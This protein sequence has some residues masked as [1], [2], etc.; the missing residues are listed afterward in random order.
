MFRLAFGT[1][2]LVATTLVSAAEPVVR[3]PVP[4]KAAADKA[5]KQVIGLFK[6]DFAKKRP[7]DQVALA[8]RLLAVADGTRDDPTA[9]Y[10]LYREAW[11]A[12]ARGGDLVVFKKAV[13]AAASVYELDALAV[14]SAGL[15]T[16]EAAGAAPPG[17]AAEAAFL[18]AE[19]AIRSDQYTVASAALKTAV[20]A[21]KRAKLTLL[22]SAALARSEQ[23]DAIRQ[24]HAAIAADRTKLAAEADHVP[25]ATRVGR[26]LCLV[27]GDWA[28]GLPLLAKSDDAALKA[29]A[30]ADLAG[31]A[32]PADRIAV[33]DAWWQLAETLPPTERLEARVRAYHWYQ[34][35]R[36]GLTG[37]PL[38]KTEKRIEEMGKVA[39]ARPRPGAASSPTTATEPAPESNGKWVVLLR[40]ADPSLWNTDANEGKDR[41][42]IP[43]KK[44]PADMKYVRLTD[45]GTGRFVIMP[46]TADSIGTRF[47]KNGY[48]WNGTNMMF[49]RGHH[50]GVYNSKWDDNPHPNRV[51]IYFQSMPL[52]DFRGW[53]FGH[54]P[55]KDDVQG[56]GWDGKEIEKTVF[57]I[58]VKSS[59]LTD[60]E[61]K[62]LLK[63]TP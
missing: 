21:G 48:G 54:R 2:A 45:T 43:L 50:L 34:L 7:A 59:E 13:D 3:L 63:N 47:E 41:Y 1:L 56:Y 10:V 4:D 36:G 15:A 26:F 37:F 31:P 23:L 14:R 35:A 24:G 55:F 44:A 53:G 46:V 27:K 28:A 8:N 12:A 58:A 19:E 60:A 39:A 11:A 57:E 18:L 22:V 9:R 25:S 17:D 38:A 6:A 30:A 42:S 5:E 52:G 40:S 62:T 51:S 33:A 49:G 29:A 20:S 61:A 16:A 32:K